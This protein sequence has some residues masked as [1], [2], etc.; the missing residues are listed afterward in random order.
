MWTLS[1]CCSTVATTKIIDAQ[2]KDKYRRPE[3]A[4]DEIMIHSN[5][6]AD[7]IPRK[8]PPCAQKFSAIARSHARITV[9]IKRCRD[10]DGLGRTFAKE[11][12]RAVG[13]RV[14]VRADVELPRERRGPAEE[15]RTERTSDSAVRDTRDGRVRTTPT[16]VSGCFSAIELKT[17]SQFG[18][19]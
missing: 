1:A 19:P 18:R 12:L 13:R 6:R 17:L 9:S 11:E 16:S 2:T 4:P 14:F 3:L 8:A 5:T 7:S 15:L 10:R